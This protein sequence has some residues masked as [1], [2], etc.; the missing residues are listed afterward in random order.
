MTILPARVRHWPVF[1]RVI[2]CIALAIGLAERVAWALLRSN[3]SSTGEAFNVAVALAQGR[4]F[5]DAFAVG[6]GPTAHLLPLP[7]LLADGVYRLL[8]VQ[9]VA[10]EGVLLGWS[11]LLTFATY[12][13]FAGIARRLGVSLHACVAGFVFLCVAPI[14]TTVEAFDFRTWEG[15]MTMSAAGAFLL[16]VLRADA[17][18]RDGTGA[19]IAL[20]LL[21]ALLLFLQPMIGLAAVSAGALLLWRGRAPVRTAS[22]IALFLA[23]VALLFG[24]WTARNSAAMGQP[25]WLRDNLGLELAVANH[26]GA[27]SPADPRAAFD[28]AGAGAPVRQPFRL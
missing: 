27:V 13:L 11:L 3:G 28:A 8:G 1:V 19:R 12:A 21:P 2:L 15:G 10:A 18:E 14:F 5:A 25:I 22:G 16:L 6:Q 17:G 9:S 4:G 24:A 20:C 26:A 23:G 7:P